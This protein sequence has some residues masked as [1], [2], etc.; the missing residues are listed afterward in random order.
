VK[1]GWFALAAA[2]AA[3]VVPVWAQDEKRP[4]IDIPETRHD[5]GAI[6]EQKEYIHNFA[7]YNRGTADLVIKEVDPACGCTVAKF[8]RLIPPGGKG[9]IEFVLDGGRVH[10]QFNKTALVVSNDPRR[11][12]M[13]IAVAGS[14][15]PYLNLKPEGTVYLHGR[16]D[17][18]VE[19]I[20]TIGSNEKEQD[21]KV[22][23]VTSN[24]DDKITYTID[25]GPGDNEYTLS[26]YKNP[27]L[28]TLITTGTIS[29]HS[30]STGSPRTD[31]QVHLMTKGSINVTPS[32]L[33]F[34]PVKFGEALASGQPVTKGIIVSRSTGDFEIREVQFSNGNFVA[35]VEPISQGKQYRVQ[36][37]FTPPPKRL[38]QQDETA[39][40]II[41][42]SDALEPAIR[43]ALAARAM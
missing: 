29:I 32:V 6:F 41:R 17:E 40:M 25:P 13:T 20:L 34:G 36:V 8:D 16:Y 39:E 12:T 23:G 11:T 3:L 24:L 14:E 38:V 2:A 35:A 31:V 7:V 10:G 1:S 30:N 42:T 21:F 9:N 19:R 4:A 33:N 18:H 27:K 15:I 28:P 37:T 43:V 5:F 22:T 26:I